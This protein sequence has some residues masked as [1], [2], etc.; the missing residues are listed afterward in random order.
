MADK[1]KMVETHFEIVSH[2]NQ[3]MRSMQ[4]N[5]EDLDKWRSMEKNVSSSLLMITSYDISLHTLATT[6]C[7]D[8]ASRFDERARKNLEGMMDLYDKFV[9]I[10]CH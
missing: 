6:V 7:Q 5:I 4:V 10:D 9:A 8:L 1:V 2:V 3:E